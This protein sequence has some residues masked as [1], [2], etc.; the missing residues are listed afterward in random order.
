[1]VK[2]KASVE[3]TVLLY[4]IFASLWVFLAEQVPALIS[5]NSAVL[6]F[7]HVY[8]GIGF[9]VFS[10]ILIY[11]LLL[12]GSS[13]DLGKLTEK[14]PGWQKSAEDVKP[15]G[16]ELSNDLDA[17]I[18]RWAQALE[19]RNQESAIHCRRITEMTVQ[20]GKAFGLS[21]EDLVN[22]RRGAYLHDIGKMALPD[23][24]LMKNGPLTDDER[25]TMQQHPDVACQLL[26]G[27]PSLASALDIPYCHH[28]KWDGSGYPRRLKGS[29]IPLPARIFAVIDVWDALT[30][31]RPF[32][33]ALPERAALTYIRS[34]SG[35]HFDPEV[36]EKFLELSRIKEVR[37]R[38]E[39]S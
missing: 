13:K 20:L 39:E 24:I 19:L 29:H 5:G 11:I 27:I 1:M 9:V 33:D 25:A 37:Y 8:R 6:S 36:V 38:E 22:I 32:R 4:V 28:E 17:L 2:N 23:S 12:A 21:E 34:Q 31:E 18:E 16:K 30:S 26:F 14:I 7:L 15:S 3:H 10:G 35:S